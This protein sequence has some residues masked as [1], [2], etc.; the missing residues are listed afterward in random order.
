VR[1]PVAG[2]TVTEATGTFV[3][4]AV[5]VP[6]RFW[7]VAVIVADPAAMPVMRPLVLTVA[8]AGLL[9]DH[10][11]LTATLSPFLIFPYALNCA[12]RPTVTDVVLGVST[13][14]ASKPRFLTRELPETCVVPEAAAVG[15]AA[16]A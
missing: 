7:L 16:V 11:T 5:A 8:I 15:A 9:L 3:T 13:T 4:R 2:L 6:L 12:V 1:A 14:C 10:V